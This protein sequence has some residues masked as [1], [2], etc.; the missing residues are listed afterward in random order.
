MVV[1]FN[2]TRMPELVKGSDLSSDGFVF[3]G[4]S[5]TPRNIFLYIFLSFGSM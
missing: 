4:S 1:Q 3:V 5:P 2:K